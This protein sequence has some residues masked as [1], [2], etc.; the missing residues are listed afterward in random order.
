MEGGVIVIRQYIDC[1]TSRRFLIFLK[2]N[3]LER[4]GER[5]RGATYYIECAYTDSS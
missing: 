2:V 1:E 3:I 4:E 5:E